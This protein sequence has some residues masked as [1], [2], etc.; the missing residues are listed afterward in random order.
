MEVY[1]TLPTAPNFLI[2]CD[3]A[4]K[5]NP[6]AAGYGFV[7]RNDIVEFLVSLEGGVYVS[8]N[9]F[10][11]FMAVICAGEWA[12]QNDHLEAC[13]RSDSKAAVLAFKNRK[14]PWFIGAIWN[15]VC[16]GLH[17]YEV[18]HSYMEVN[19]SADKLEKQGIV[20]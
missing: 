8:T 11:E 14:L 5:G 18:G 6:S 3:E 19:F 13:F 10:A 20:D 15:K 1:F 16:D 4:S 9:F 2:C 17:D 7:A 12:I